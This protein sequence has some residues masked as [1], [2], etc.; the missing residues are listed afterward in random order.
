MARA[1]STRRDDQPSKVGSAIRDWLV[2]TLVRDTQP[3]IYRVPHVLIN[4]L[5][6]IGLGVAWFQRTEWWKVLTAITVVVFIYSIGRASR[7]LSAQRKAEMAVYERTRRVCKHPN[8]TVSRPID[9]AT[10]VQVRRWQ[11]KPG[12]PRSGRVVV[13]QESPAAGVAGRAAAE[14]AIEQSVEVGG[15]PMVF[16][17][18]PGRIGFEVV[19]PTDPRVQQR[20]IRARI[21]QTLLSL[22]PKAGDEFEVS[23][24]WPAA[25]AAAEVPSQIE[26]AFGYAVAADARFRATVERS[27]D[28]RVRCADKEWVYDWSTP[29]ILVISSVDPGD[30]EA[31]R[32]RSARKIADVATTTLGQIVRGAASQAEVQV[33]RWVDDGKPAAH[34]PVQISIGFGTADFSAVDRRLMLEDRLDQALVTEW[35]DRVWLPDWQFGHSG[36]VMLTAAPN[37]HKKAKQRTETKHLREIVRSSSVFDKVR[38]VDV[39]V[40]EWD[41]SGDGRE[42]VIQFVVHYGTADMTD[43]TKRLTFETH[44]DSKTE[45]DWR[46]DWVS[47]PG[48]LR[49]TAVPPLPSYVPFPAKGSNDYTK[50]HERFRAGEV[51]LGPAKGGNESAVKFDRSPHVLIGGATGKGKSQAL[52]LFIYGVLM[53]PNHA[54]MV[55]IDFKVTDWSWTAGYPNVAMYAPTDARKPYEQIAEAV[56]YVFEQ[57]NGRQMLLQ[58]YSVRSLKELRRAITDG[59]I[60]DLTLADVPRRLLLIFD[61]SGAAFDAAKDPDDRAQQDAIRGQIGKIVMLGRAMEVHVVTAAQKPSATNI[62]TAIMNQLVNKYGVGKVDI[63]TSQQIFGGLDIGTRGLEGAP[64]GRGWFVSDAGEQLLT[65]TL[66][67]PNDDQPDPIEPSV[68]LRGITTQVAELLTNDGWVPVKEPKTIVAPDPQGNPVES[69]ILVDRWNKPDAALVGSGPPASTSTAA[70]TSPPADPGR[71]SAPPWAKAGPDSPPADDAVPEFPP[72]PD[73][74]ETR[75]HTSRRTPPPSPRSSGPS[76]SSPPPSSPRPETPPPSGPPPSG[77]SRPWGPP[78]GGPPAD[79]PDPAPPPSS[80]DTP[81]EPSPPSRRPF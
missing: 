37:D 50:W 70:S 49:V 1:R 18:E 74:T 46:F 32:K 76:S 56:N 44:L 65:Q 20:K 17:H 77:P 25:D 14:R 39:S 31:I 23:V 22:F 73:D 48:E 61:E 63:Y 3:T 60:T 16:D 19:K 38:G 52:G 8:S 47:T 78:S 35:P 80:P 30:G 59:R 72:P 13:N 71:P 67:L 21:E 12:R 10:V 11:R 75:P 79:R 64:L 68:Q 5:V 29:A 40:D 53:N 26:V 58:K 36:Q 4:W 42:L 9:P 6:I 15:Q 2:Y 33:L 81:D 41:T 51:L 28:D 69:I 57:M 54:E 7:Q 55:M 62:G 66:Y 27:F 43:G 34:T 45:N 24:E